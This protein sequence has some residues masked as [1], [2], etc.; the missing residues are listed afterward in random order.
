MNPKL[1]VEVNKK[2]KALRRTRRLKG[3]WR[4]SYW[5]TIRWKICM[6]VSWRDKGS[7]VFFR[8]RA[9]AS[10]PT[11]LMLEGGVEAGR[12]T[13][14]VKWWMREA[15]EKGGVTEGTEGGWWVLSCRWAKY[16]SKMQINTPIGPILGMS[17]IN[18][19]WQNICT[20]SIRSIKQPDKEISLWINLI[21]KWWWRRE[22]IPT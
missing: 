12:A 5:E 20:R 19:R 18:L 10:L 21:L 16:R 1:R 2:R 22:L 8:P 13:V 7:V 3:I 11:F 4:G 9:R 17:S 14:K 6:R 15:R